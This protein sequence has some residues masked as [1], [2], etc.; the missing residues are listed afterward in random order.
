MQDFS[1]QMVGDQDVLQRSA[2]KMGAS[3]HNGISHRVHSLK[4]KEGSFSFPTLW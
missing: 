1:G 4:R 2:E 3:R